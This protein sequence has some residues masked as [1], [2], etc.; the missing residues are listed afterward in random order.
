LL[1]VSAPLVGG[2]ADPSTSNTGKEAKP[3]PTGCRKPRYRSSTATVDL[4]L[5]IYR[6]ATLLVTAVDDLFGTH[7]LVEPVLLL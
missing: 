6:R 7:R 4:T 5:D 2:L 1:P 3:R